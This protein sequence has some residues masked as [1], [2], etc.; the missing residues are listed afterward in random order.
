MSYE[1]YKFVH[2]ISLLVLSVFSTYG[3][4]FRLFSGELEGARRT[5][6]IRFYMIALLLFL[7]SG[8]GLLAK[9][10][11]FSIADMPLAM[12]LKI[13]VWFMLG[14]F[15]SVIARGSLVVVKA[16]GWV[17]IILIILNIYLGSFWRTF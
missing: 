15:P 5:L 3:F 11:I 14:F 8:F 9:L 1:F 13:G 10:G 4:I 6:F 16:S 12:W 2:L 7:V 17:L